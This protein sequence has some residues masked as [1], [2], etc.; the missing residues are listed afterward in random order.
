MRKL[1][2]VQDECPGFGLRLHPG[3][4]RADAQEPRPAAPIPFDAMD[5]VRVEAV[6]VAVVPPL[7][8]IPAKSALEICTAPHPDIAIAVLFQ[9]RDHAEMH[10]VD[11]V[12]PDRRLAAEELYNTVRRPHPERAVCVKKKFIHR[13]C[14]R[15]ER[16][17]QDGPSLGRH[18]TELKPPFFA[19]PEIAVGTELQYRNVDHLDGAWI[20]LL[21]AGSGERGEH[22]GCG[23]GQNRSVRRDIHGGRRGAR[24][25]GFRPDNSVTHPREPHLLNSQPRG[26]CTVAARTLGNRLDGQIVVA[27]WTVP[28]P[29]LGIH[30]AVQ[31]GGGIQPDRAV[32]G[33]DD[34]ERRIGHVDQ[35]VLEGG[36]EKRCGVVSVEEERGVALEYQRAVG[37]RERP[38]HHQRRAVPA[39]NQQLPPAPRD[40]VQMRRKNEQD[41]AGILA[42]SPPADLRLRHGIDRHPLP[43]ETVVPGNAIGRVYPRVAG[44]GI[45]DVDNLKGGKAG[46]EVKPDPAPF[47]IELGYLGRKR[48]GKHQQCQCCPET[49]DSMRSV[50]VTTRPRCEFQELCSNSSSVS[51]VATS[52]DFRHAGRGNA[53][54]SV[55]VTTMSCCSAASGVTSRSTTSSS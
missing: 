51:R 45:D 3:R 16:A 46:R 33:L 13:S 8:S 27:G 43:A 53:R 29:P 19:D 1:P 47:V 55:G 5:A 48:T 31:S 18:G 34:A 7:L 12:N 17:L 40:T 15:R 26:H 36:R 41:A 37:Q 30:P 50:H 49:S 9:C 44:Y 38:S 2:V 42:D 23:G 54:T 28:E 32:V 11:L 10:P 6:S 14:F 39:W 22:A 4:K 25:G 35:A 21:P 52:P 20:N 24:V